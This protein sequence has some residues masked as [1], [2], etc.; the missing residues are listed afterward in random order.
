MDTFCTAV[1]M[2]LDPPMRVLVFVR[3]I[4]LEDM[5]AYSILVLLSPTASPFC[6]AAKQEALMTRT[7]Y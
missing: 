3:T 7:I 6:G 1:A 4:C 2:L 5:R